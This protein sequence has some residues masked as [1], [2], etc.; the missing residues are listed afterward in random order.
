[1]LLH[2]QVNVLTDDIY[3]HIIFDDAQFDTLAAVVPDL[4][5]RVLTVNGVSKAYSMTGWRLGYAG[6][7]KELVREMTKLQNQ[8]T[9]NPCS[10]SQA[11]AIE[12]L[13][14]PQTHVGE[15]VKVFQE[16]RDLVVGMLKKTTGFNCLTPEGAFY[17]FP[18]C[19][20]LIGRRTQNGSVI[21]SDK[22]LVIYLLETAGVAG[23]QGEAYGLSPYFRLSTASDTES[24]REACSRIQSA[25]QALF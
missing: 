7:S 25:C 18:N 8:N 24:L 1:M 3:E 14:G 4:Y 10:I 2:P 19:S 12:A 13:T 11:A 16:R 20:E 6:G 23:V 22:D 9:G 5:E 15:R 17:V 21:R